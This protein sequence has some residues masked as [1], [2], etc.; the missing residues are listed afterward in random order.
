MKTSFLPLVP[1]LLLLAL[2]LVGARR[3]AVE[4]SS[5]QEWEAF[6]EGTITFKDLDAALLPETEGGPVDFPAWLDGLDGKRVTVAGFMAPFD[7]LDDLS[8]FMLLPSY[9]GC[10]FCAPPSFTQVVLVR[11]EA[12]ASRRKR[13]FIDPPIRVTGVLRL[14]RP[15]SDHPA[16]RDQFV[17]ALDDAVCEVLS[18][19]AEPQRAP[20]HGSKSPLLG[21]AA[22]AALA[23]DPNQPHQAFQPQLLVPAVSALRGLPLMSELRFVKASP[24][25]IAWR[26]HLE[27]GRELPAQQRQFIGRIFAQLGWTSPQSNWLDAVVSYE[28]ERRAGVVTPNG[29][30]VIY[31]DELP[32][33]K[34]AGRLAMAGLIQEALWRQNHPAF[35]ESSDSVDAWLAKQA[36][37]KGDVAVLK[38][39]Y[40]RR[41]WLNT[42]DPLPPLPQA[43]RRETLTP[44]LRQ[45]LELAAQAGENWVRSHRSRESL[46]QTQPA[47]FG[48]Y[49]RPDDSLRPPASPP[50][51]PLALEGDVLAETRLGPA[52]LLI[53]LGA[54]QEAG[55][56]RALLSRLQQDRAVILRL[57]ITGKQLFVWETQWIDEVDA[58][59]FKHL[60]AQAAQSQ[61]L[62]HGAERIQVLQ[63]SSQPQTV[64]L[65]REDTTPAALSFDTRPLTK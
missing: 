45:W 17:Y 60:A 48:D 12:T 29:D 41:N 47:S 10:Y 9:V 21:K 25:E 23:Q 31:H 11:Q 63:L 36:L 54:G 50:P 32:L 8:I 24:D 15:G 42:P 55:E 28:A 18:G 65:Q 19:D 40:V 52:A 64:R 27:L 62:P 34:P 43:E 30:Q 13:P 6:S 51:V 1:P 4:T 38:A 3:E 2:T 16:H 59:A 58:S 7:Q 14:Y 56:T 39:D 44:P 61:A 20:A 37:R 22:D 33:S 26:L 57:P 5:N 53:W 35:F 49:W 46:Y